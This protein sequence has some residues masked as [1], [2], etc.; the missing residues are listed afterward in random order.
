MQ[1][2]HRQDVPPEPGPK[3]WIVRLKKNEKVHCTILSKSMWG[4]LTHWNGK[5]SEPCYEPADTCP[6]CQRKM[7]QRWKG[8]LHIYDHEL[9]RD[10]FLELTPS[11]ARSIVEQC[12][13]NFPLRGQRVQVRRMNG[14]NA[15]LKV[16]VQA[17]LHDDFQLPEEKDPLP[18]L[19]ALWGCSDE[20]GFLGRATDVA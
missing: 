5:N 19:M 10:R 11:A 15:R 13:T 16:E 17:R 6:G 4:I 18:T 8:Y 2:F 20:K 7:A 14:D 3:M 1:P 9:R 12:D